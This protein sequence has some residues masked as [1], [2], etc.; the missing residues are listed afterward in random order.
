MALWSA[1]TIAKCSARARKLGQAD[2]LRPLYLTAIP[3]AYLRPIASLALI[4]IVAVLWLLPP[5][6]ERSTK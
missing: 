4:G 3:A 6:A 1:G 5:K 2:R